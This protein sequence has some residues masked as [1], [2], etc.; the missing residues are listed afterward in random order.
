[1]TRLFVSVP[2]WWPFALTLACVGGLAWVAVSLARL[3][4]DAAAERVDLLA[5]AYR[6]HDVTVLRPPYDWAQ[7]EEE[8]V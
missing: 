3:A 7:M 2:D 6:R 4:A 8:G 5:A 1:M